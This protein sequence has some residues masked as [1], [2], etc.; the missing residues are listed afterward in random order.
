MYKH[1]KAFSLVELIVVVAVLAILGSIWSYSY[2]WYLSSVRDSK[3]ITELD[4]IVTSFETYFIKKSFFPEPDNSSAI[5]F[6]WATVWKQWVFWE[7][8]ADIVW[9]SKQLVV[10]PKTLNKYTYSVKDKSKEF[11]IAWVLEDEKSVVYNSLL[12]DSYA[13]GTEKGTAIVLW[14]YN[15]AISHVKVDWENIILAVPTIVSSYLSWSTTDL[16]YIIDNNKY[17]YN[18]GANLPASYEWTEFKINNNEDFSANYLVLFK[19]DITDFNM[20]RE[21]ILLLYYIESTYKDTIVVT[22]NNYISSV[23]D[24]ELNI[25]SPSRD[26]ARLACDSV[27]YKLNYKVDCDYSNF[28]AFY[29]L[30]DVSILSW[31]DYTA[32][33]WVQINYI[34]QTNSND[35]WFA[36]DDGAYFYD[37]VDGWSKLTKLG[38]YTYNELTD[39]WDQIWTDKLLSND[40]S[41]ITEDNNW[42]IWIWTMWGL[43]LYDSDGNITTFEKNDSDLLSDTIT[44]IFVDGDLVYIWSTFWVNVYDTNAAELVDSFRF[45]DDGQ[46]ANPESNVNAIFIDYSDTKWFWTDEWLVRYFSESN[47]DRYDWNDWL[48]YSSNSLNKTNV[49]SI[50]EDMWSTWFDWDEKLWIWTRDWVWV[51]KRNIDSG[52]IYPDA[53]ILKYDTD[54]SNLANDNV[55]SVYYDSDNDKVW[56]WTDD[57][58]SVY[59]EVNDDPLVEW[60]EFINYYT[61]KDAESLGPVYFIY[62]SSGST[63]LWTGGWTT[64]LE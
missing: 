47:F 21:R 15:W 40:I 10:D 30:K 36:T 9:Y 46:S 32:I 63:I 35:L 12:S 22:N 19:W 58:V 23:L 25:V 55:H 18:G 8:S 39:S 43:I 52:S 62:T 33:E 57:W 13:D 29:I 7:F 61:D 41:I 5:T 34:Y 53:G 48:P 27:N 50:T 37:E 59:D 14:N 26:S 42:D 45:W 17:V 11:S 3:R 60:D 54:N 38:I 28:R 31:I 64:T 51:M 49:T 44:N 4:N 16:N 24:D 1:K 6:S 56:I 2:L 20:E